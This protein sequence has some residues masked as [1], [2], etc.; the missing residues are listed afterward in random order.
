MITDSSQ[1]SGGQK[2]RIA[3]ARAIVRNP[4]ILL[5]DEATSALDANSEKHVQEAL[6][7]A[8]KGRTTIVVSHRLSTITKADRILYIGNGV[9]LED[10]T[11]DDLLRL[12]GHYYNLVTK[13]NTSDANEDS[14]KVAAS[15]R[16]H[17]SEISET[18]ISNDSHTI[19]EISSGTS[20]TNSEAEEIYRAPLARLLKLNKEDWPYVLVGGLASIAMG[21]SLPIFALIFS[22]FFD[23]IVNQ[24]FDFLFI[25]LTIFS[26]K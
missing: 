13:H 5:L 10:G 22:R 23:V 25:P 3:I 4:K 11:H 16:M 6:D 20:K 12:K 24:A 8:S 14:E 2:Q 18:S 17:K 1:L 26:F 21:A 15:L 7:R 9:I 19:E